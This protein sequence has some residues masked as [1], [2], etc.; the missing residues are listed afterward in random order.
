MKYD[1]KDIFYKEKIKKIK[2]EFAIN[3]PNTKISFRKSKNFNEE[4]FDIIIKEGEYD[5]K[6]NVLLENMYVKNHLKIICNFNDAKNFEKI[7]KILNTNLFEKIF[8]KNEYDL[9]TITTLEDQ[10][11]KISNAVKKEGYLYIPEFEKNILKI[12]RLKELIGEK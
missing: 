3:W 8:E 4:A 2:E 10:I 7:F 9:M 5:L 12:S 1:H 11:E 6:F